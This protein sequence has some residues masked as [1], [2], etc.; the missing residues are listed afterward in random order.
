MLHRLLDLRPGFFAAFRTSGPRDLASSRLS[1]FSSP[2]HQRWVD[3]G[4]QGAGA[5]LK[6]FGSRILADLGSL[7]LD[8]FAVR[9]R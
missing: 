4:G 9:I 1:A 8:A 2:V 3:V 5:G 6:V 7:V